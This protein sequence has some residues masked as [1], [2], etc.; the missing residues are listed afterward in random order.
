VF[1]SRCGNR[2]LL[3]LTLSSSWRGILRIAHHPGYI[4][5]GPAPEFVP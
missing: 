4:L 2:N 5:R 1:L 3:H